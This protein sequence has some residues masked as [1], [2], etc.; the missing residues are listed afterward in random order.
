VRSRG[1]QLRRRRHALVGGLV[2]LIALLVVVPVLSAP[3]RDTRELATN[4]PTSSTRALPPP[5]TSADLE[6]LPPAGGTEPPSQPTSSDVETADP[7]SSSTSPSEPPSSTDPGAGE[8]LGLPTT[9]PTDAPSTTVPGCRQSFRPSCGPFVW[10]IPPY[11]DVLPVFNLTTNPDPPSPGQEVTFVFIVRDPDGPIAD[12]C[13]VFDTGDGS[14]YTLVDDQIVAGTPTCVLPDCATPTG[15]WDPP[16]R[17]G[18][19]RS[20]TVR[21]TYRTTGDFR[22]HISARAAG[23]ATCANDP[24]A[25][26]FDISY[27]VSVA[28]AGPPHESV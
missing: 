9:D 26:G 13:F 3:R 14:L 5:S 20:F 18:Q 22:L 6:V 24:Y 17:S 23:S 28:P 4:D 10:Q 1:T 19:T 2:S 25:D 27:L 16:Q 12:E 8:D 7:T 15:L 11:P 21:H